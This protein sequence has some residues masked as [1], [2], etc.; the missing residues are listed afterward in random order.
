M[1]NLQVGQLA[2]VV[3][4]DTTPH[5][6]GKIVSL[7]EH[8]NHVRFDDGEVWFDIWIVEGDDLVTLDGIPANQLIAR[9]RFLKP[10]DD[11]QKQDARELEAERHG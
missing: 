8:R 1:N 5:N 9:A 7:V 4:F 10:L 11:K 2:L 3:G 6:V